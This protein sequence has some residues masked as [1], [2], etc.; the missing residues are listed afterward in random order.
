MGLINPME[1]L[2]GLK[3]PGL[4]ITAYVIDPAGPEAVKNWLKR[5]GVK[6]QYSAAGDCVM[7]FASASKLEGKIL[8]YE[9]RRGPCVRVRYFAVERGKL[10]PIKALRFIRVIDM[11]MLD[12]PIY[13][14]YDGSRVVASAHG[15]LE[16]IARS[17]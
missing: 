12:N 9:I 2:A 1:I 16:D 17:L 8:R 14:E 10:R 11:L 15:P 5:Y 4:R 13:V 7:A 6:A 3:C